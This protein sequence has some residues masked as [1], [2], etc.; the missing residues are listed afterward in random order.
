ME[1]LLKTS[2][3]W[4]KFVAKSVLPNFEQEA[5]IEM[6]MQETLTSELKDSSLPIPSY[7]FLYWLNNTFHFCAAVFYNKSPPG[8]FT[9]ASSKKQKHVL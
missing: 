5:K 4:I 6:I 8:G 2:Q 9:W 3:L 7:E 1:L